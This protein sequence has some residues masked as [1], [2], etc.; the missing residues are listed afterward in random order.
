MVQI[1]IIRS[2][3]LTSGRIWFFRFVNVRNF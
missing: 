2:G 1:S 3:H